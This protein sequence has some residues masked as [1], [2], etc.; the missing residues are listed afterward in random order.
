MR[1]VA[2]ELD[3]IHLLVTIGKG[4]LGCLANVS[5]I[6]PVT[7]RSACQNEKWVPVTLPKHAFSASISTPPAI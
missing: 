6:S 4:L 1:A 3:V 5:A 2:C 7:A